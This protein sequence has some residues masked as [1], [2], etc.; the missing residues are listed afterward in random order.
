MG[1]RGE[2]TVY[3][4]NPSINIYIYMLFPPKKN[5]P[6]FCIFTP[7]IYIYMYILYIY[8]IWYLRVK[9][10]DEICPQIYP[11]LT[12]TAPAWNV[13]QPVEGTEGEGTPGFR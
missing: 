11:L 7:Y 12:G 8:H 13:Y 4:P 5:L 3:I 2:F 6:F 10:R 9:K 1:H